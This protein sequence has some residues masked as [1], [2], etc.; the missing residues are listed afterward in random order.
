[1]VIHHFNRLI[2]NKW[3]WGVFAV[4][5]SGF[6]AFDFL[7]QGRGDGSGASV[8][9]LGDSDMDAGLFEVLKAE[10]RRFNRQ[11]GNMSIEES[12]LNAWQTAAALQVARDC[13]LEATDDDVLAAI[14]RDPTFQEN[15]AFSGARYAQIL[16]REGFTKKS[17][18]AALKRRITLSKINRVVLGGAAWVSPAELNTAVYDVTDNFSVRVA[19]FLDKEFSKVTIDDRGIEAYYNEHTNSIALPDCVTIKYAKF[20]A[21][22]PA[23]LAQFKISDEELHERYDTFQQRFEEKGTNG[24]TTVKPFEAVKSILERELQV[25]A[26]VDAYRTNLFDRV[27]P[28]NEKPVADVDMLAKIAAEDKVKVVEKKGIPLSGRHVEGFTVRASDIAP[29]SPEFLS[30]IADLD[31]ESPEMRYGV[32][33]GTNAV[34]LVELVPVV[35][36]DKDGSVTTNSFVQAHVPTFAEA[37]EVLRPRALRDAQEKAFKAKVEK[38]RAL[39]AAELA[40]GGS[41]DMLK[42]HGA[43]VSTQMVFSVSKPSN[44]PDA[45]LI[46]GAMMKLNKGQISDVIVQPSF[47]RRAVLVYVA[48][49][50]KGEASEAEMIKG[51]LRDQLAGGARMVLPEAWMKWNLDRIGYK[52]TAYSAVEKSDEAAD[53][54]D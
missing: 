16:A 48:D 31:V 15:G 25:I 23:R 47:T 7:F 33:V 6:F 52:T 32:A 44:I 8:G 40:K 49:R 19:S 5:I 28:Q 39:A 11:S 3:I 53:S 30:I 13:R 46:S 38:A 18:E 50:T 34:Y 1:M 43:T 51:S 45:S 24:V 26:S 2:K 20:P 22:A 41:F 4:T 42:Q 12:N 17:Y 10:A 21:D 54:E 36:K 14:L 35:T 37:K 29:D 27:Y 9:T